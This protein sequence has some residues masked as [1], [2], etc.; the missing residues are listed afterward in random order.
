[1]TVTLDNAIADLRQ[2]IVELEHKLHER[3]AE[4]SEAREQQT[5]TAE[6]LQ[7]INSS[8]DDLGPVLDTMLDKALRLCGAAYGNL[9]SYDGER[10]HVVAAVHGEGQIAERQRQRPPIRATPGSLLYPIVRGEHLVFIEDVLENAAYRNG[11]RGSFQ[12]MV[13]S[14]GYRSVLNVALRKEDALLGVIGIFRKEVQG[15]SERQ[16]ELVRTFADHAVIAIE[17]T[18]LIT[19]TREALEQQ[20]ATAEVLGVI[21]SSPGD[22]APVFDA[23][24]EKAMRLCEASFGILMTHHGDNF[25]AAAQR[26][27]PPSFA[28]YIEE[29]PTAWHGAHR[30]LAEGAALVHVLDAKGDEAYPS[31]PSRRALVDL[32]G[33]RT[34]L[35]VPLRRDHQLLGSFAIYRQEVRAFSD[36]QIALLQNF[37][38]QAVIAMENARLITETREALEQQTATAEVLQVIN[39]SPGDLAPVFE[40]ILDKA[41]SLCG[42]TRGTLF[43]FDGAIFRAAAAHGYP[44]DMTERLR[45]G[46]VSQTADADRLLAGARLVHN[47]DLMQSDDPTARG[48]AERGGIRTNLLLPLRKDGALL[49]MISCNRHE[50]RPF[51]DRE[52]ALLENFAA[53]AVIAMEN[54]RLITETREALEQQTATTE[55]LQVI[56]SSPGDLAPVF[57]AMLDKALAFCGAVF[58]HLW[59]YDGEF[60][61]AAALRGAPQAYAELLSQQC[62]RAPPGVLLAQLAEGSDLAQSIDVAVDPAYRADIPAVRGLIELGG[63]RTCIAVPLRK[64]ATLLGA[65]TFYRQEIRPFSDKQIALMQN[66]AAQAVIAMENARLLSELQARTADLTESLKYQT[67]TSDVL[68][69]ISRSTFDLQPVLDTLVQTAARLFDASFTFIASREGDRYRPAA[70]FAVSPEWAA[71]LRTQSFAA[72]RGTVLGRALLEARVVQVA[73]IAADPEHANPEAVTLGK[74]RTVLGVPLLREGEAT[75]VLVLARRRVEPFSERQIELVQTFADQAVIAIENERL[76]TETREALDQQTATAEVLQV[77]NSSPGDLAPVFDAMLEK[78]LALCEASYG[79]LMT[80]DGECFHSVADRDDSNLTEWLRDRGPLR[81]EPGTSIE[82]IARGENLIH[83]P[84]MKEDEGYR[85]GSQ[86]RRAL[87]DIGG[88]RSMLGIALRKEGKLLGALHV[89]RREARPFSNKQIALLQNFAAQAVIAMENARLITETREARDDAQAA[90]RDLRAAQASL[91]QAEKMASLGQLTA[92]IAHEIKNPLNFVNNFAGLSVELLDELRETAAPA[93]A[94]LGDDKRA[95]VDETIEMLTSNLDKIAE[96]GQRADNIVKSMLE[97]SRGVSGDRRTVDLNN[98]IDEALNLAYHGA[99]AQDQSFNIA[100]DVEPQ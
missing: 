27:L 56:N 55:V 36:K 1:M 46:I 82:R 98:L 100:L 95:E 90:L 54:A 49:G 19:E 13:D 73:D 11:T 15:F 64:D 89:Y 66:F 39:S 57:D 67:A 28:A 84:D 45:R 62:F 30:R 58:G 61:Q 59:T 88:A 16:I 79:G 96:H 20:T 38:A 17:N 6:V 14:G 80:Y 21:N 72:D 42:A 10:F 51:T 8:P 91:I 92:G 3:T 43:L 34:L 31:V 33:A 22:L 93:L 74:G 52:I 83:V 47:P 5:A 87:V 40:T 75:G 24:L 97:H 23:M 71:R 94:T 44:E 85:R 18:R 29:N 76:I 12:E 86:M 32:G 63:A 41:H 9:L 65:I 37:A 4:L 53:Q 25:R 48:L 35:L 70:L 50:V 81:P 77:I 69:V 68:K 2:T 7:A 60:F 78:A 99:R 26:G